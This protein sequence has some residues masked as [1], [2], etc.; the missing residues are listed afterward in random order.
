M[1]EPA[2]DES[3]EAEVRRI[4][5]AERLALLRGALRNQ[6][7]MDARGESE[8]EPQGRHP[9]TS[10]IVIGLIF[11]VLGL[12]I[13]IGTYNSAATSGGGTYVVA[14]GPMIFGFIKLI[15][16]LAAR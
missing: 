10:S 12:V 15:Q 11:L 13:T 6:R 4:R 8:P 14:Y 3:L 5:D 16:G 1:T 7:D 2:Q 9:G